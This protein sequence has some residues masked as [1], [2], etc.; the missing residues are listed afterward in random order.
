MRTLHHI[1]VDESVSLPL[2][3]FEDE[4][5]YLLQMVLGLDAVVLLRSTRPE[6][7]LVELNLFAVGL[8]IDHTSEVSVTYGQG[9]QPG[10]GW[11]SIPQTQTILL[12]PIGGSSHQCQHTEEER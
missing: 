1:S 5:T 10:I 11:M 7:P 2:S 9:L 12:S 8:S 6:R 3:A 4:L